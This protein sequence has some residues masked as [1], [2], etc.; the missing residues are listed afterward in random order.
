MNECFSS[1]H[2]FIDYFV[3]VQGILASPCITA[4]SFTVFLCGLFAV[5]FF[6]FFLFICIFLVPLF[7]F[8][9]LK[10]GPASQILRLISIDAEEMERMT[11]YALIA[12]GAANIP[13]RPL[14]NRDYVTKRCCEVK[15]GPHLTTRDNQLSHVQYL[16]ENQDPQGTEWPEIKEDEYYF[17]AGEDRKT[18]K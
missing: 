3:V 7:P 12:S 1:G 15:S 2:E 10:C 17:G 16:W 11:T 18:K 5:L 4:D 6:R 9:H 8:K 13:F 14:M